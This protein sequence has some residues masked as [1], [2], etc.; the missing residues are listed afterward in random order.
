MTRRPESGAPESASGSGGITSGPAGVTSGPAGITVGPTGVSSGPAGVTIGPAAQ[1]ILPVRDEAEALPWVL[2]RMPAGYEPIVVDNGSTDG[3]GDLARNLGALVVCESRPGFGAACFAGLMAATAAV[4]CFMDADGSLDPVELPSVA[5]P[6]IAGD[7]DLVLGARRALRGAQS[8]T[9]MLANRVLTWQLS[10]HTGTRLRDLG[11]MRAAN[12]EALAGLGIA[13]RRFGWP[14][15]MVMR[16]LQSGWVVQEVTVG[17]GPRRGGR[18]KVTGTVRGTV[19]TVRDMT[20]VMSQLTGPDDCGDRPQ[21]LTS[22]TVGRR[23]GG[24]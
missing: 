18:S 17:Y 21:M 3:S 20:R 4:V 10:R 14:L 2:A 6:V 19:R 5:G 12:R 11:P 15:E 22:T 13:D 7:A 24:V 16:A 23:T 1:V 8:A 9:N